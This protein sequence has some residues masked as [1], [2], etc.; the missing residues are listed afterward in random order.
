MPTRIVAFAGS[1][2][3]DSF[4]KKLAA[5]AAAGAR[6]TGAEV[7]LIDLRDLPMPLYDGD[8]EREHGLPPHARVFKKL[9]VDCDAMLISSAEYNSAPSAVLKNAIDWA[10]RAE[11]NEAP[12]RAFKGKIVGLM[13]SSPG[14]LGGVRG[15]AALRSIL[16]N[17]GA[18]VLPSQVTVSRANEAFD[19]QGNLVDSRQREQV[20]NLG[21]EV[22]SFATRL[23]R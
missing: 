6:E 16:S 23:G 11:A 21:I 4:N 20:A 1:L 8:F 18:I 7:N 9:L 10:S 13:S 17:I 3:R 12:L 15:L 19:A 2:R 22:A 14:N 5:L